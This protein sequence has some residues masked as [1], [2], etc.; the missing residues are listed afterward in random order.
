MIKILFPF[1]LRRLAQVLPRL[2]AIFIK[3]S[4]IERH[5]ELIGDILAEKTMIF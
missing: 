1:L 3:K 5:S 4:M 2:E